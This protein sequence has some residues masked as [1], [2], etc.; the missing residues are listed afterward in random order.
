MSTGKRPVGRPRN[1]EILSTRKERV[2]T[3]AHP[4]VR[5]LA[6]ELG[7]GCYA[8]YGVLGCLWSWSVNAVDDGDVSDLT[9]EYLAD[10][11]DWPPDDADRLMDALIKRRFI[12]VVDGRRYIH[13]WD[14]H[15]GADIGSYRKAAE[16]GRKR[17]KNHYDRKKLESN[18]DELESD[19]DLSKFNSNA[20]EL[21]Y[22][23][24]YP[25]THQLNNKKIKSSIKSKCEAG[26]GDDDP[27]SFL[28]GGDDDDL[29]ELRRIWVDRSG[30]VP[31][32]FTES[33][34]E[35]ALKALGR[36]LS[37]FLLNTTFERTSKNPAGYF[38][39]ALTD[40]IK[41]DV[42]TIDDAYR[43]MGVSNEA[44]NIK[45]FNG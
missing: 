10:I 26:D 7:V 4:K 44:D 42:K 6:R 35:K 20:S 45:W 43:H 16:D 13:G 2:N 39:Q 21:D 11:C 37:V 9:S 25:S 34:L 41:H 12:D 3:Y 28:G 33:A 30:M 1:P 22:H 36:E 8:A 31:N 19:S 15:E 24:I 40:W 32:A 27:F 38:Y 29:A 17:S 14:E 5:G 23:G 18:S